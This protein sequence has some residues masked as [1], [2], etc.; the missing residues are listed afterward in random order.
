MGHNDSPKISQESKEYLNECSRRYFSSLS[1]VL[2][3]FCSAA[4]FFGYNLI[5]DS[6]INSS[7]TSQ[8]KDDILIQLQGEMENLKTNIKK[9]D[10]MN[11]KYTVLLD[12]FNKKSEELKKLHNLV[13]KLSVNYD[14]LKDVV[15]SKVIDDI[16]TDQSYKIMKAFGITP[17]NFLQVLLSESDLNLHSLNKGQ[18]DSSIRFI[19]QK[20]ELSIDGQVG[21]CTALVLSSLSKKLNNLKISDSLFIKTQ[22]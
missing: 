3:V 4:S 14:V 22:I 6:L 21:P 8:I 13:E 11:K 1:A 16:N 20:Y 12:D 5:R 18:Y 7:Y 9:S 17:F 2:F 15:P 10:E 19:Q